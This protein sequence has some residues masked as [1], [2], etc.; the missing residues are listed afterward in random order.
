MCSYPPLRGAQ[1]GDSIFPLAKLN[2]FRNP[3]NHHFLLP[4]YLSQNI[5]K[6]GGAHPGIVKYKEAKTGF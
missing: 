1:G 3:L 6:V 4:S 2:F 5:T